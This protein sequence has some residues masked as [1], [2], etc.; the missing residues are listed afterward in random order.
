MNR[1]VLNA[2]FI[3]G[4]IVG[5]LGVAGWAAGIAWPGTLVTLAT[6]GFIASGIAFGKLESPRRTGSAS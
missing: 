6:F 1:S 2:V 4:A 5:V 3:G